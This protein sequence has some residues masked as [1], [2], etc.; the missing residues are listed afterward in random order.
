[1]PAPPS[2]R[3]DTLS[4]H[5]VSRLEATRRAHLDAPDA[6]RAAFARVVEEAA[7]AL[8]RECREVMGDEEQARLLEREARETFL[9][10]YTRM[11]LAQNQVEA[12]GFGGPLGDGPFARIVATVIAVAIAA[13]LSRYLPPLAEGLL[14]LLAAITPVAP[15]LRVAWTRRAWAGQL[16]ELADDLGRLQDA[17]E[18]LPRTD[19]EPLR[20][21]IPD[22]T[23]PDP[24]ATP[25]A[26]PPRTKEIH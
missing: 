22:P 19:L 2:Y 12:R 10:R 17:A 20:P 23:V 15:E 7:G 9:P 21:A 3:L 24:D 8:A 16:Q 13:T 26:R 4:V 6:A 25:P 11:A 5:L 18:T 14:F 1:M